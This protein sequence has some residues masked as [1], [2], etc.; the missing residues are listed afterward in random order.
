MSPSFI[1]RCGIG[2]VALQVASLSSPALVYSRDTQSPTIGVSLM[3]ATSSVDNI[4]TRAAT[5][6][7][8][9]IL[10]AAARLRL[11]I[12]A[13]QHS[14][15]HV[16]DERPK[17]LS[18]AQRRSL[19]GIQSGVAALRVAADEPADQARDRIN[20][21]R[22]ITSDLSALPEQPVVLSSSPSILVPSA[23]NESVFT[24]TG[25]RLSRADPRLLFGDVVA[26]R[27]RLTDQEALFA[28]PAGILHGSDRTPLSYSGR[29]LLSVRDCHWLR[30]KRALQA[31]TVSVLLLPT[32]LA[33]VRI[34]F[35]RKKTQRIYEQAPTAEGAPGSASSVMVYRRRFDYSTDDLTVMSCTHES[36]APH[37]AGYFIDTDSLSA[38]VT[39]RSGETKWSIV[40]ASTDGF[41]IDL[42]AQPQIDK[43]G[44]T[45][46][47]V[48]VEATWKEFRMG[49]V[50][51]P[52]EGL[53]PEALSWGAQIKETL[54][55]ETH[56]IQVELEYF[57]G[58]RASFSETSSDRYVEMKWDAQTH[59][60]VLTPRLRSSL[61]DVD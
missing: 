3:Q 28:L 2:A 56:A 23:L 38:S 54:P 20:E 36:Q 13:L 24:L 21:I 40:D 8:D 37:A 16:L 44:K 47:A 31:Y 10:D 7:N 17:D 58:S 41:S 18:A 14:G 61:A 49:E 57:D 5:S 25:R 32:R 60:L 55:V 4:S 9:A 1:R 6:A 12:E 29:V 22:Q 48:S 27:K 33:T 34:G 53:E 26:T 30:C 19:E 59:Q 35:D 50:V 15:Q 11:S 45:T 52:R 46:G 43:M 51:S 39:E 42:C